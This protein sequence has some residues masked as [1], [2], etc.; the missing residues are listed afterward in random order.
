MGP[1]HP[2]PAIAGMPKAPKMTEYIIIFIIV[3]LLFYHP[4][5]KKKG[6]DIYVRTY[7]HRRTPEGWSKKKIYFFNEI[8]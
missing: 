6:T 1:G 7:T 8:Y 5:S 4:V 2:Q 3:I